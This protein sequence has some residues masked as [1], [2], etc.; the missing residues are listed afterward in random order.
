MDKQSVALGGNRQ[1]DRSD[2]NEWIEM[3]ELAVLI[4]EGTAH[5]WS[6]QADGCSLPSIIKLIMLLNNKRTACSNVKIKSGVHYRPM[7]Q[8]VHLSGA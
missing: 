2:R 1:A 3:S 5:Q 4:N 6:V 8:H 7:D